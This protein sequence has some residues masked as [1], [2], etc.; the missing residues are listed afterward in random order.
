M[1]IRKSTFILTG[2]SVALLVSLPP[3]L[4]RDALQ[5]PQGGSISRH[6]DGDWS[7]RS[8]RVKR[9]A[10]RDRWG[11]R[12]KRDRDHKAEVIGKKRRGG[13]KDLSG[14]SGNGALPDHI[15][16]LGT[17]SGNISA[18]RDRTNGIYLYRDRNKVG[19]MKILT[20]P[21]PKGPKIIG[22]TPESFKAA[23]DKHGS[24]CVIK[25]R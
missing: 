4:A 16:N 2:V 3:V 21:S 10:G 19:G 13:P 6:Q 25:A 7:Y 22:V 23:C 17:F 1:R 8:K 9:G 24:V 14:F 18:V 5:P 20:A 12:S 15:R 11:Y